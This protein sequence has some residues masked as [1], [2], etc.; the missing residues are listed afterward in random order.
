MSFGFRSVKL[1]GAVAAVVV[2]AVVTAPGAE[3]RPDVVA[4][5]GDYAP[6]TIVVKTNERK[7]YLVV[8][9]GQAVR[10]PVGVGK[11]GKRWEGVTK[12]DGKYRNPAWAPPA[13]VKRDNPSIP[14][15]IPG[16]TPENP[17]GVAAMTLAGGEYAI[18][19]TNRPNSVGGFVSY[20]C[21]RMLNDD[22]SDLYQRV[23]VGTQVVV[24][25]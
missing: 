15:V 3:A 24:T 18:H 11:P 22:I 17:M 7:L 23:P 21:I 6:G 4:F 1:L 8:E 25:R 5:R 10:Y 19:G 13:D 12:I 14:D 2:A 16:G 20:G 9:P